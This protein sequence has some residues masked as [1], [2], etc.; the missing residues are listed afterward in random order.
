[1]YLNYS[2]DFHNF[3]WIKHEFQ[4]GISTEWKARENNIDKRQWDQEK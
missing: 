4:V 2:N 3:H 1:M